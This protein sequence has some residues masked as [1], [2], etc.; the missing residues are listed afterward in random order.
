M[1]IIPITRPAASALSDATFRPK[2][3]PQPRIC[4]ATVSAA[5]KPSTTVGMPARISRIGLANARKRGVA[6]SDKIDRGEE[7]ERTGHADGDERDQAAFR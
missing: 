6:Y 7:A 2:Y 5:K 3:S 1:I 4:G